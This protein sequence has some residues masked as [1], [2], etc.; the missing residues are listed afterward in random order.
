MAQKKDLF[1]SM[2]E[3]AA[4]TSG[5]LAD[6][7]LEAKDKATLAGEFLSDKAVEAK[8][9]A[10]QAGEFLGDKATEAKDKAVQTRDLIND[11]AA[12]AKRDYDLR[13]FRPITEEQLPS[14]IKVMPEMVQIVDWDKRIEE[15][16]C[17]DAVA[18][19]EGNK[20]LRFISVL[21]RNIELINASFY[22][23]VQEG[24]YYRDPCNPSL[25]INLNDYFGYIKKA[26][27]HELNQIAQ[28][29]GAKHIK[30]TLKAEKKTSEANKGKGSASVGKIM[31]TTA[32]HSESSMQLEQMEIASDK[33]FKGHDAQMPKLYYFKNEP[34]IKNIIKRRL[35]K[36][37]PIYSDVETFRYINSS[38]IKR[39]DAIKIDGALS[40][41][42]IGGD[43][44]IMSQVEKE[45][46]I[47]FE[48]QIEYPEE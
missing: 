46:R 47:F 43:T 3:K 5:F 23:S 6:K 39:S 19:N 34:D 8:D 26:K 31:K 20:E 36:S 1:K 16:V 22:P 35:D 44:S 25:Y 18:F 7:A 9:K 4:Q 15:A 37:N 21:T 10:S 45:E 11:K 24:V 40:K 2:K 12:V 32:S 28:D 30:I 27:V 33:K 17:K 41:L 14:V 48:Y 42:K 13:R 29:L 38:G